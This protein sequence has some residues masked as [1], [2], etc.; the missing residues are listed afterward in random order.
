MLTSKNKSQRSMECDFDF[1]GDSYEITHFEDSEETLRNNVACT[2]SLLNEIGAPTKSQVSDSA[3]IWTGVPFTQIKSIF[4]DHF[5]ISE[6]S[7]LNKDIPIF[8][9]WIKKMNDEEGKYTHWNV[10]VSGD[11]KADNR[12]TVAGADVG[13]IERT[14]KVSKPQCIDIGSL[15]SGIDVLCDVDYASLS[16]EQKTLCDQTLRDKKGLISRRADL[17]LNNTPLLL[18]YRIDKDGG[19]DSVRRAK[20]C[21]VEDI[22]GFSVIIPGESDG[23]AHAKSVTIQL[24]D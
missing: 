18:L 22:I 13:K 24:P 12:W 6:H 16:A 5:F 11:K 23:S 7:T 10:A 17:N 20:I 15:R 4:F 21:T 1:S 19:K 2:E 8:L 14:K 9:D 3:C